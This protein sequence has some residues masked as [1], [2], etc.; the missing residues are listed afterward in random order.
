MNADDAA[1]LKELIRTHKERLRIREQ[2]AAKLGITC[3]PEILIE[4]DELKQKIDDA[5]QQIN[6]GVIRSLLTGKETIAEIGRSIEHLDQ[7]F[8]NLK[9]E[10]KVEIRIIGIPI[11]TFTK[12]V[13]LMVNMFPIVLLAGTIS[14][15]S[16][17]VALTAGTP[18]TVP[19]TPTPLPS[20]TISRTPSPHPTFT[21]RPTTMPTPGPTTTPAAEEPT[22]SQK[23]VPTPE[24]PLPATR[25][26]IPLDVGPTPWWR[27]AAG[28]ALVVVGVILIVVPSVILIFRAGT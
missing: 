11:F 15:L 3:P 20:P 25:G 5:E 7:K 17:L 14:V 26:G 4:I 28:T 21:P 22:S 24:P 12:V 10:E 6:A 18:T 2:Q 19:P 16:G 27:A 9:R 13:S 23:P 8:R 1:H